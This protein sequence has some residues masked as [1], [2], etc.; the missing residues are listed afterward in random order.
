M[1]KKGLSVAAIT[2]V[3]IASIA[4][5]VYSRTEKLS[6]CA[7][8]LSGKEANHACIATNYGSM[9]FKLDPEAAPKS[10]DRFKT[11]SNQDKF[12]NGLE[13][14]RVSK[15]FVVQGG[16]QD[17]QKRNS[18]VA[19]LGE[20]YAS[21]LKLQ[22]TKIDTESNFDALGLT[23]EE[24]GKLTTDGFKS[25]TSVKTKHFEYGSLSFANAGPGTNSTE[26]FIATNK[27]PNDESLKFLDGRFTNMGKIVG[28]MDVLDKMNN[29]KINAEY[30]YAE[31]ESEKPLKVIEIRE[32]VV[33]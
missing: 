17:L 27:T 32:V 4:G 25:D 11:L 8:L 16:I 6:S 13:F 2:I 29:T 26:I 24:R 3:S 21:K 18:G 20:S 10:V 9:I 12:Y 23:E 22:D 31:G 15:D 28:G 33:K 30:E 19:E 1:N 5:Y 7:D 14:Y